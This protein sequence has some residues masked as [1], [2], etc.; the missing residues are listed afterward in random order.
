MK[1][2]KV[3]ANW[4]KWKGDF[5]NTDAWIETIYYDLAGLKGEFK[6]HN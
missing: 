2:E 4:D 3:L 5:I 1:Q 6:K